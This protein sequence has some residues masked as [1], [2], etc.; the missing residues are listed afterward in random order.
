MCITPSTNKGINKINLAE[1]RYIDENGDPQ[2]K[3]LISFFNPEHI[4][5]ILC[6]YN[7]L[8]I[9]TKGRYQDDFY[10]L[11]EDFDRL[12]KRALI[13]YPMYQDIIKMKIDGRTNLEIKL[14]LQEKYNKDHT[15]QY[16]SNLWRNKIPK[17]IAEQE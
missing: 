12:L 11:M 15:V 13:N 5:A 7:A 10:Y 14:M 9:E 16:I 8:K 4:S 2:S 6:H 3:G 17:V 1:E